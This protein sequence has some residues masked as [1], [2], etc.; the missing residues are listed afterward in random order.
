MTITHF[1]CDSFWL[2][3]FYASTSSRTDTPQRKYSCSAGTLRARQPIAQD[4]AVKVFVPMETAGGLNLSGSSGTF[5]S[6]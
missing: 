6:E 5:S 3:L 2:S 1:H 4:W